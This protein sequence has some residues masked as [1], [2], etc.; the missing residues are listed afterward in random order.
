MDNNII[1]SQAVTAYK[2]LYLS[3]DEQKE[4]PAI[5]VSIHL[6]TAASNQI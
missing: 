2:E 1:R 3:I 4:E 6:S 5:G